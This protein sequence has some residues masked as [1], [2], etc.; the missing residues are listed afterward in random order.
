MLE[1]L[2]SFAKLS[3]SWMGWINL[4]STCC[5]TLVHRDHVT[6]SICH[7]H[8]DA[9]SR[10]PVCM[11]ASTCTVSPRATVHISA[12]GRGNAC[13]EI[14]SRCYVM[15][16][17]IR[18]GRRRE[19][20]IGRTRAIA[21]TMGE[22]EKLQTDSYMVTSRSTNAKQML[23]CVKAYVMKNTVLY[24]MLR[25]HFESLLKHASNTAAP[26]HSQVLNVVLNCGGGSKLQRSRA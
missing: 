3:G 12:Q 5:L 1:A 26:H 21:C 20:V 17:A 6:V 10:T 24:D 18:L 15:G 23:P 16:G 14:M 4:T 22:G 8:A 9:S 7:G 13:W 19:Q 11:P 2:C 25:W